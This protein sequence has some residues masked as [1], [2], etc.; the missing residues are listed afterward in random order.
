MIRGLPRPTPRA[1]AWLAAVSAGFLLEGLHPSLAA[2]VLAADGV[3]LALFLRDA[4]LLA[5]T[6]VEAARTVPG[7]LSAGRP[8]EAL[9]TVRNGGAHHLAFR[10]ADD[11]HPTIEG[12][13]AGAR[14]AVRAGGSVALP[15]AVV[16]GRRGRFPLG[17]LHLALEGPAG[18]AVQHRT[19]P[20]EQEVAVHPDGGLLRTYERLLAAGR[21][22][23]LGIRPERR[24]VGGTE[25]ADLRDYR[26]GD[27]PRQ[28][29]WKTTVRRRR[30]TVRERE[31]ERQQDVLLLVDCGRL[32]SAE[33]GG[34]PRLESVL[35][36]A[37]LLAWVT[38]RS[39]D[40]IGAVL[41]SSRVH[42]VLPPRGGPRALAALREAFLDAAAD[43]GEPD[44]AEAFGTARSL[45]SRRS[46]LVV[47]TDPVG[48]AMTDRLRLE[49]TAAVR[50]H[51]PVLAA[52]RDESLHRR[53]EAPAAAPAD[54]ARRAA[55]ESRV[56]ERERALEDLR[57]AGVIV[58]DAPP[59]RFTASAVN[60]YLHVKASG[61]L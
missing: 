15:Y 50:R 9:L 5:R 29:D 27:D 11:L 42:A 35:E 43:L 47:L 55:A 46:L 22:A 14:H 7:R 13:E 33:E 31:P 57:A 44:F 17:P 32:M 3:L 52:L 24:R 37:S 60:A 26:A 45:L 21:T 51:L 16:P 28:V 54:L 12:G 59:S 25:F 38:V 39:Q 18:F 53:A 6:P 34:R 56:E 20:G 23:A 36:A 61:R 58:V 49:M 48:T 1:C 8:A 2:A 19:F 10:F 30:I 41:F 40:R 4:V